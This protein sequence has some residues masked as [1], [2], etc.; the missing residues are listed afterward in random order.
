VSELH[1]P[2]GVA[3]TVFD[4]AVHSLDFGSGF[5]DDEEVKA[6]RELAVILEVDPMKATPAEWVC[7]FDPPHEWTE[8]R[9]DGMRSRP[10]RR[11]KKCGAYD[12]PEDA[13][14]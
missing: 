14:P 2:D 12:Y 11:C 5:L 1:V 8:V 6:L 9:S 13:G 3:R 7:K 10:Y 4:I